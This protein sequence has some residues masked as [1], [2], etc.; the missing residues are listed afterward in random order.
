MRHRLPAW[1]L[2]VAALGALAC[3]GEPPSA[4]RPSAQY[5]IEDFLATVS[6]YGA[7]FSPDNSKLLVSSDSSGVFNVYAIP[8]GGGEPVPL[9]DS[10]AE[11][12]FAVDYFPADERF[13]YSSDQGGNELDHL[14]V[15]ELDGSVVDLTPGDGLK[16]EFLDWSADG[17]TFYVATN[18]RDERYFD[19]YEYAVDGYERELVFVNDAGLDY[20]AVSPDGES[21]ALLRVNTNADS[22]MFVY[23]RADGE[24]RLLSAHEG[25][26]QHFPAA[27]SPDGASLLFLTDADSE[28]LYLVAH[29]LATDE[30][31]IVRQ[32][33]WDVEF[34][35]YS[36]HGKYLVVGVNE[37]ARTRLEVTDAAGAPVPLPE[38][39]SAEITSVR[40]SDDE[41]MMAFYASSSRVPRDLFVTTVGSTDAV[42]LTASLSPAIDGADLVEAQIVRFDS[43][44][45]LEIP[46]VLYKPHQASAEDP[47]PAVVYV[48]GGPG[49]QSRTGY[50]P[51][52]QYLV[53]HGYVVYAINNRGSSGYGKTFYHLDDRRHGR[54]D[55]DDCVASK[56]MLVATGNVD[57]QRIGILG[58]SYGGYMVLAALTFRPEE[59]AVGVDIFG[60]SN[61]HRTVQSIPPW[62]ESF[63]AALEQELGPF[64]D[65]EAF[66]EISPLFHAD[67][68]VKPLMVLQ[69]ANDPR[70]LK[71]ESD[72]I[73]AA[74]RDR[75]VP[76][77]YIVFDDEGHGFLKKENRERGYEGILEFLDQYLRPIGAGLQG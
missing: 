54:D 75:G 33:D 56:E 4:P 34:A 57:P 13:L 14:F 26:V 28:F 18:E 64:D 41:T 55:L 53:N 20:A 35:S 17:A 37:D 63:R 5:T 21:L 44:D 11:S 3:A 6:Y 19:V 66:R 36:K 29:D 23:R 30:R 32:V 48:H 8:A 40:F 58:G 43:F 61:W 72:D 24:L 49:G 76:V 69:G 70:V 68:I 52:I 45:G 51:L 31:R 77:E 15:R 60:I 73:V 59:F 12:I 2:G 62:W 27:F 1:T 74:V 46:G 7:S 39:A 71:A 38:M 42:Q 65:E 67:N 10:T 22:D 9:T 25:D 16:A 47:A 50:N